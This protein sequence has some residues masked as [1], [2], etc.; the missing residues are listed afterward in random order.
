MLLTGQLY[1]IS[2]LRKPKFIIGVPLSY[3]SILLLRGSNRRH[4][5]INNAVFFIRNNTWNLN[6]RFLSRKL[7]IKVVSFINAMLAFFTASHFL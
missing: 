3:F 1:A 5:N 2:L 4:E 6:K 7:I